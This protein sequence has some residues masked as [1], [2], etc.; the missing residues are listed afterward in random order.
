MPEKKVL[1]AYE[2][3][4]M[5]VSASI[6]A[7][8]SL[9]VATTSRHNNNPLAFCVVPHTTRMAQPQGVASTMTSWQLAMV[10]PEVLV[11]DVLQQTSLIMSDL[12]P[13][14]PE[15]IHGAFKIG[16]FYAQPFFLLMILFPKSAITKKI[17][18]GLGKLS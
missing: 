7:L 6:F 4:E 17:M 2:K 13:V 18:G 15:P 1:F 16:T 10:G 12:Y 11:T 5:R 14:S 3:T 9:F 8:L